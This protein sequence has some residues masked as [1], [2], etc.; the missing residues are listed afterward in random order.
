M[1]KADYP[2]IRLSDFTAANERLKLFQNEKKDF[3]KFADTKEK[4][5]LCTPIL[6]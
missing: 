4:Y 1:Q 6:A 2:I 3:T 5:Y